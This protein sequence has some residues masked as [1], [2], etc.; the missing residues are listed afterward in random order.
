MHTNANLKITVFTYNGNYNNPFYTH[1][2]IPVLPY[3]DFINTWV[4]FDAVVLCSQCDK[5]FLTTSLLTEKIHEHIIDNKLFLDLGV[6][7]NCEP[8]I[9]TIKGLTLYQMDKLLSI[10]EKNQVL[11]QQ[12]V[13]YAN[14]IIDKEITYVKTVLAKK[15]YNNLIISLRNELESVA[16][17]RL[18]EIPNVELLPPDFQ[19][20]YHNTIHELMHISQNHLE[21]SL[22]I[23]TTKDRTFN[24]YA[25][26]VDI[27][28]TVK[29]E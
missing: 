24:D 18:Q 23:T 3:T 4:E 21:N 15:E 12:A 9:N 16:T 11:R 10:V 1:K 27:N 2:A 28:S 22:N 14:T 26:E 25:M 6:P 19:R 29:S 8:E 13:T 20:W 7:R 5:P 17:K